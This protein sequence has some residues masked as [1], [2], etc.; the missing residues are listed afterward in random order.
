MV[1]CDVCIFERLHDSNLNGKIQNALFTLWLA[2]HQEKKFCSLLARKR[3]KMKIKTT[4]QINSPLFSILS[5]KALSPVIFCNLF[6]RKREKKVRLWWDKL[7]KLIRLI[8]SILSFKA[9][10]PVMCG[11][12]IRILRFNCK[13]SF[14]P[15][16]RSNMRR[17]QRES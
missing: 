15:L 13:W 1:I 7:T 17:W 4:Y 12:F 10:P 16:S 14:D 2:L 6:V 9:L 5:F 11:L 8:F 3:K